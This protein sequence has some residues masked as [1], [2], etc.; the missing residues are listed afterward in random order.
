MKMTVKMAHKMTM[1]VMLV[2]MNV[3]QV[4]AKTRKIAANDQVM[5]VH[6][7][8]GAVAVVAHAE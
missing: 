5:V 8:V 6:E 1:A 4:A 7:V 3:H 2:M